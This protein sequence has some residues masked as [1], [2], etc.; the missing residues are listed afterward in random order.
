MPGLGDAGLV[1]PH[2]EVNE[3]DRLGKHGP[4]FEQDHQAI[5]HSSGVEGREERLLLAGNPIEA[6]AQGVRVALQDLLEPADAHPGGQLAEVRQFRKVAAV[7]QH[8]AVRFQP[9][10]QDLLDV[11]RLQGRHGLIGGDEALLDQPL[12]AGV[13]PGLLLARGDSLVTDPRPGG[14]TLGGEPIETRRVLAAR[15]PQPTIEPLPTHAASS[16]PVIQP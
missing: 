1:H 11:L 14:L 10:D 9:R 3:L 8:D 13:A 6:L 16:S 2:G 4:A 7:D 5:V 15:C 12:D